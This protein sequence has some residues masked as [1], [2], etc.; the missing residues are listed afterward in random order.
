MAKT[1]KWPRTYSI[2]LGFHL[3][4]KCTKTKLYI[5]VLAM[6]TIY[7]SKKNKVNGSCFDFC[8]YIYIHYVK[9]GTSLFLFLLACINHD[10]FSSSHSPIHSKITDKKTFT[11]SKSGNMEIATGWKH[12]SVWLY[13]AG[14]IW[15]LNISGLG[16]TISR[17]AQAIARIQQA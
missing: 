17:H 4:I 7:I 5:G 12:K 9:A 1:A 3:N 14:F 8:S 6:K 2:C 15:V 10:L 16:R 13:Q 11:S